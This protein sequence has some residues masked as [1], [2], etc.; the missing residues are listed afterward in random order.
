[1]IN[2]RVICAMAPLCGFLVIPVPVL[3]QAEQ[4]AIPLIMLK[5]QGAGFGANTAA[6][7]AAVRSC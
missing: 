7:M 2:M 3:A 6:A 1:M 4:E 5:P